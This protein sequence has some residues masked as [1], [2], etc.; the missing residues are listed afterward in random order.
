MRPNQA[1]WAHKSGATVINDPLT[2]PQMPQ[3]FLHA[4][5]REVSNWVAVVKDASL[6]HTIQVWR[7]F[8]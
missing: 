4:S 7:I 8:D 2:L 5:E 6:R 3:M 1:E